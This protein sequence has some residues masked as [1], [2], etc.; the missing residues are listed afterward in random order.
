MS[1]G[2][3]VKKLD[4]SFVD[5]DSDDGLLV[6][7]I[8]DRPGLSFGL[9]ISES[10]TDESSSANDEDTESSSDDDQLDTARM[11]LLEHAE[12]DL[13]AI[14]VEIAEKKRQKKGTSTQQ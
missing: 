14:M 5:S 10:D 2:T 7:I 13:P 4:M 6:D 12:D 11:E 9:T 8:S 3:T 1:E